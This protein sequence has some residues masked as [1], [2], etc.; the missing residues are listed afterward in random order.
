MIYSEQLINEIKD[1]L[2]KD[3]NLKQVIFKEQLGEDLYFEALG[4]ERGSE[5]SFRYKPQAKTLFHKLNN[6]WSQIKGYQIELT[7]Q[8]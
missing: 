4:M 8:M 6:N 1:V 2:K 7:N 5:Y 3:F